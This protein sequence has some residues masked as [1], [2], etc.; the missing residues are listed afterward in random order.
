MLFG[1]VIDELRERL[2]E[3]DETQKATGS[4]VAQLQD[5]V[6][7]LQ[8]LVTRVMD[9]LTRACDYINSGGKASP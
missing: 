9:A 3:I 8:A 4:K 6:K 1:G 7:D 2:Q 5:T